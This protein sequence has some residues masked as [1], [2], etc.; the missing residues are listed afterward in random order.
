MILEKGEPAVLKRVNPAYACYRILREK[1]I[2]ADQ[3]ME[4]DERMV[5]RGTVKELCRIFPTHILRWS[6]PDSLVELLSKVIE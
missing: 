4:P 6:K 3:E 2:M 5:L 1:S